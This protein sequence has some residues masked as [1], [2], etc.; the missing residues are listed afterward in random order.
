MSVA[1]G[2]QFFENPENSNQNIDIEGLAKSII[3]P[4]TI[5]LEWKDKQV[6]FQ[7]SFGKLGII[8]TTI[9]PC[10]INQSSGGSCKRHD[11][12]DRAAW[13]QL[14]HRHP[15]ER[16]EVLPREPIFAQDAIEFCKRIFLAEDST[17]DLKS[18]LELVK[19]VGKSCS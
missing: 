14:L 12:E 11:T 7:V 6:V 15:K 8:S 9:P 17:E 13:T 16:R 5:I 1:A 3:D 18:G 19:R 2:W 4:Y 10:Y